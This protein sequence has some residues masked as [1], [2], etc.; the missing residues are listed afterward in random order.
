[1]RDSLVLGA[2]LPEANC[3]RQTE[4]WHYTL[5]GCFNTF[6]EHRINKTT[7]IHGA[8]RPIPACML[9]ILVCLFIIRTGVSSSVK[10]TGGLI[11]ANSISDW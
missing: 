10:D 7:Q 2:V 8:M 5:A 3:G 4:K 6:Q 9:C 1:M 11:K